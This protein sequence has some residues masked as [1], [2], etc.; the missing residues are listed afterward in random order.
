MPA[1]IVRNTR[2]NPAFPLG[3]GELH[4]LCD[5][6]LDVLGLGGS[7]ISLQL[8]DDAIIAKL[9]AEFLGCTGPTNVL[10]FPAQEVEEAGSV[11]DEEDGDGPYLG[12]IALSVDTLAREVRLYGQDEREHLVRLLAHAMLHLA[13]YD[14]GEEMD[15][16]TDLAV[17]AVGNGEEE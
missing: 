15:S 12:E 6:I 1:D 13:G 17:A 4:D 14:H 8:V 11:A 10:S 9:N 16:L 3:N 5:D 7:L 2:I